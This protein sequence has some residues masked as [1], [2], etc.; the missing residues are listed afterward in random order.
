MEVASEERA[1]EAASTAG[2]SRDKRK[3]WTKEERTLFEEALKRYGPSSNIV[4]A[5]AIGSKTKVQVGNYKR[6]FLLKNPNWLEVNRPPTIPANP[7]PPQLST[8]SD[9]SDSQHVPASSP[10]AHPSSPAIPQP[11]KPSRRAPVIDSPRSIPPQGETFASSVLPHASDLSLPTP[12]CNV[13]AS[14]I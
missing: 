3:L 10:L 12:S 4:L 9:D 2:E 8:S 5:N 13:L 14:E 7:L 11:A 6:A 1:A